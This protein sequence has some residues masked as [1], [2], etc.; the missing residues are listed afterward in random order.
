M[1][2]PLVIHAGFHKTGTSSVQAFLKHNRVHLKPH[3]AIALK[4]RLGDVIPAARGYSTWRDPLT[5]A[6]FAHRIET[7]LAALPGVKRRGLLISAE[8]LCGHMPGRAGIDDYSAAPILLT[9]L[10][11]AAQRVWPDPALQVVLTT[12]ARDS[13]LQSSYWEHVKSSSLTESFDH[14]AARIG[15]GADLNAMAGQVADALAP[16]PLHVLPIEAAPPQGPATP[17]L[18]LFDLPD[19]VWQA[20]SPVPAKNTRPD[21]RIL[22]QML[23]INRT[24]TDRDAR[25]RAK[26]ALLRGR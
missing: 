20:L 19:S 1:T 26:Q 6:K 12:R 25:K 17:I 2:A 14:Y 23:Q 9:E 16:I 21:P 3:M 24:I 15:P 5:L 10:T 4:P 18:K 11:R 13:W 7:F 22:E 8:E